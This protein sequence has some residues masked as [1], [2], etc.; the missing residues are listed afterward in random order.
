MTWIEGELQEVLIEW[1]HIEGFCEVRD[2]VELLKV[3]VSGITDGLSGYGYFD[4]FQLCKNLLNEKIAGAEVIY[5]HL[6]EVTGIVEIPV[7][8][9]VTESQIVAA[10]IVPKEYI[11]GNDE[12][13]MQLRLVNKE[14]GTIICTKTFLSGTD[15]PAYEVTDFGPVN[16]MNGEINL[17]QG[18]SFVKENFG[19]GMTLPQCVLIIQWNLR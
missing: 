13:Y 4:L 11:T 19:G 9:A 15:A 8:G 2:D 7:F 17:G 6:D 5:L 14:T 18:V 10:H 1:L 3:K 12:N 16:E